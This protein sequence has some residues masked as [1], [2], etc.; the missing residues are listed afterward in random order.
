MGKNKIKKKLPNR[1]VAAEIFTAGACNLDCHYCYIPKTEGM[2]SVHS[3]VVKKIKNKTY[4]DDLK[5]TFGQEMTVLSMWGTEPTLTLNDFAGILPNVFKEF[6]KLDGIAFS[7]N[8]ITNIESIV[9]IVDTFPKERSIKLDVQVSLDGPDW[10]TDENRGVGVTKKIV[11][12]FV[13]LAELFNKKTFSGHKVFVKYK[14]TLNIEQITKMSNDREL[15]HE[16]FKFFDELSDKFIK[17]NNNKSVKLIPASAN[18]TLVVPGK[19]TQNDG[20]NYSRFCENLQE[21]SINNNLIHYSGNLNTYF[22]RLKRVIDFGKELFSK[23]AMF[24]CS[25]GDS[26]IAIGKKND[27]HICHRSL[28]MNEPKYLEGLND[29]KSHD[30]SQKINIVRDN[31]IVDM[32]NEKDVNQFLY[33][34]AGYHNFNNFRLSYT[35]AMIKEMADSGLIAKKYINNDELCKLLSI[36]INTAFSCPVN[37]I[38]DT[39]S[40]HF[41]EAGLIK[42]FGNGAFEVLV[43]G[44]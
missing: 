39:G 7:T 6:K 10:I 26:Q 33:T 5:K 13:K 35:F 11:E 21:Y 8:L 38:L 36:F 43:K 29:I 22:H 30:K 34:T 17:A 15:M 42:M 41:H 1:A 12:N 23:P 44:M 25:G 16:F 31:F 28:F 27:I 40:I 2:K 37:N 32:N 14:P 3:E 20:L 19:Y 9:N 4:I 18:I 24:S